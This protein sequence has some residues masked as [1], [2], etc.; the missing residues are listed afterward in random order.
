MD[1][2]TLTWATTTSREEEQKYEAPIHTYT[3]NREAIWRLWF[4]LQK[5]LDMYKFVTVRDVFGKRVDMTRSML[6]MPI[7]SETCFL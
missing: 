6:E 7:Y 5:E 3:G 2:F 4:L 1:T